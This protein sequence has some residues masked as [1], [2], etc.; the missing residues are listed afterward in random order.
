MQ[1]NRRAQTPV[2]L[3][4]SLSGFAL[5]FPVSPAHTSHAHGPRAARK[6]SGLRTLIVL[7]QIH[8]AVQAGHLI[9]VAVEQHRLSHEELADTP[10]L[11][12][13]PARVIDGRIHV[14]VK[15][16]FVRGLLL[17]GVQ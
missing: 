17:P 8:A 13:A 12:L 10:L 6:T 1:M 14:G 2:S 4:R 3:V 16:V 15:A 9:P 7:P 5:R 11:S